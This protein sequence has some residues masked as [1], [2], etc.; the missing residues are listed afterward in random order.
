[1]GQTPDRPAA[2]T[3]EDLSDDSGSVKGERAPI[4]LAILQFSNIKAATLHCL[5][6]PAEYRQY[7]HSK[8]LHGVLN[9]PMQFSWL[10]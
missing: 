3:D 4:V 2:E 6:A 5:L 1:M 9:T 7:R 10:G 8:L